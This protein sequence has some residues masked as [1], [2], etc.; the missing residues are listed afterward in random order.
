MKKV[1]SLCVWGSIPFSNAGYIQK[2]M[3]LS[4]ETDITGYS[5]DDLLEYLAKK[6]NCTYMSDLRSMNEVQK[7]MLLNELL[8]L[9]PEAASEAQWNE[10]L[11]YIEDI[12]SH[13]SAYKAR[14]D[15]I[16]AVT[17]GHKNRK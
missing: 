13:E 10:A 11:S 2:K 12:H 14:Q 7:R 6:S 9:P 15:L 16:A 5:V 3:K 1:S 8:R 4:D 17:G